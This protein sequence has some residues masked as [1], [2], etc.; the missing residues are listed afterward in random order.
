MRHLNQDL[1]HLPSKS[2]PN[3]NVNVQQVYSYKRPSGCDEQAELLMS[4]PANAEQILAKNVRYDDYNIT[5]HILNND[6]ISHSGL[7]TTNQD[8]PMSGATL[9][10]SN[11]DKYPQLFTPPTG[12]VIHQRGALDGDLSPS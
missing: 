1:R 12:A 7:H 5:A 9:L 11:Q 10:V 3:V 8:K 4:D 2:T 6:Y